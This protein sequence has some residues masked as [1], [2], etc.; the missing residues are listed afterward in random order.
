MLSWRLLSDFQSIDQVVAT[1]RLAGGEGAT[2][3][4]TSHTKQDFRHIREKALNSDGAL[5]Q[6][7]RIRSKVMFYYA[8][9][10][11]EP[12]FFLLF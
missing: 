7:E 10:P 12:I 5:D 11:V 2:H 4:W 8:G 9:A 3:N 1:I 6:D